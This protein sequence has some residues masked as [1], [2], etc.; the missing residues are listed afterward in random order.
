M[1]RVLHLTR[2]QIV[3]HSHRSTASLLALYPA[4]RSPCEF[5]EKNHPSISLPLPP[6]LPHC[7]AAAPSLAWTR[8]PLVAATRPIRHRSLALVARWCWWCSLRP[9]HAPPACPS[10]ARC[11]WHWWRWCSH[12]SLLLDASGARELPLATGSHP[13]DRNR[14]A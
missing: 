2:A 11:W 8:N 10:Q 6:Q 1:L 13:D 14:P 7:L 5:F 9:S 12:A 3:R 4:A